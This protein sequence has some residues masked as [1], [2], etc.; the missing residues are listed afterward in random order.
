MAEENT[1]KRRPPAK[2][3][4][5]SSPKKTATGAKAGTRAKGEKSG[6]AAKSGSAAKGGSAANARRPRRPTKS[7]VVEKA[8][9]SYFDALARRD[10]AAAGSHFGPDGI[11]DI[12]PLGVFRGPGEVR[13]LL[14]ELFAAV[15]DL[16]FQVE[17]VVADARTAAV[18]Y[19]M[20]GTFD[21]A[22]F[23]GIEPT[24]RTLDL[25]GCDLLE[26]EDG[27]IVRNTGYYDGAAFARGIGLLPAQDSGAERAMT[28][29]FN[30]VT[31]ARRV[32][33]SRRWG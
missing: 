20:S 11:D 1:T 19:R 30:L 7:R 17:R 3:S 5:A 2:K 13:A 26:I 28:N 29:A 18:E 31:R 27:K 33:D 6:P 4:G 22:P 10:P 23:Q 25:R 16:E 12:V 8:A 32:V 9:R 21:G 14:T 15:P 24:G